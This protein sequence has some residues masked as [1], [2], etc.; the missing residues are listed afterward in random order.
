MIESLIHEVNTSRLIAIISPN[1]KK[2]AFSMGRGQD[3]DVKIVD[4]S[5][6]RFHAILK[7][8]N[9]GFYLEDNGA[10]FG[11]LALIKKL[12]LEYGK[13]RMV[14]VGRTLIIFSVK[15][16]EPKSDKEAKADTRF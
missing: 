16:V 11:T 5:V 8:K 13:T 7:W 9:D 12:V 6:S 3:C 15:A 14:Q 10:K 4:V 1:E 2:T